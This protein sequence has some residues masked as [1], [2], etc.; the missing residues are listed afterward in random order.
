MFSSTYKEQY[1]TKGYVVIPGLIPDDLLPLLHAAS[2]NVISKTRSGKWPHRRVVG[3]QF[4]PYESD[5]PDSWG[6]QH[7]MHPDLGEDAEVFKKWYTSNRLIEAVK[8]LIPCEENEL[9]MGTF[10]LCP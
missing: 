4:P 3:K 9:Q 8:G 2:E 1:D 10:E 5:N 7:V 6:V